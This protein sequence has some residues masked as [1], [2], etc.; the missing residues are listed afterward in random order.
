MNPF[1]SSTQQRGSFVGDAS[2]RG[3]NEELYINEEQFEE[4][5]APQPMEVAAAPRRAAAPGGAAPGGV[6]ADAD[7]LPVAD[8][9][10]GPRDLTVP[11]M[12]SALVQ[13]QHAVSH[14]LR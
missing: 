9:F 13:R 3:A 1:N 4:L 11:A 10:L 8:P 7:E 5:I 14:V 12:P 6:A 2:Q